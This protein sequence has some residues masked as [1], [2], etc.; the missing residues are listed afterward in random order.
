VTQNLQFTIV[1]SFLRIEFCFVTQNSLEL[2]IFFPPNTPSHQNFDVFEEEAKS[3]IRQLI[4][5]VSFLVTHIYV[6]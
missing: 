5:K 2:R 3:P 1:K 6:T 4:E